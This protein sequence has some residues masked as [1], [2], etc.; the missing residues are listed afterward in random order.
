[1]RRAGKDPSFLKK[2]GRE[3]AHKAA[4]VDSPKHVLKGI[5]FEAKSPDYAPHWGMK[6]AAGTMP[7]AGCADCA[8]K[9]RQ[10]K[11]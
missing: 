8:A 5:P 9:K 1:V 10:E 11:R 6:K 3:A 7:A 2:P 4:G